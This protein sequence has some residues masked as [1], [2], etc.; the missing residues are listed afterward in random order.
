[1]IGAERIH[2]GEYSEKLRSV[3]DTL[4]EISIL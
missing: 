2:V 1:M 4:M 3:V